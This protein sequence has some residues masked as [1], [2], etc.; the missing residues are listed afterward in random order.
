MQAERI[1]EVIRE[2][3]TMPLPRLVT[4]DLAAPFPRATRCVSIVGPRRAG[5]T[6]YLYQRMR[7]L[8]DAG[9]ERTRTLRLDFEDDRL[10]PA[11]GQDL[12]AVWR[13]YR[14]MYPAH[15]EGTTHL[16][17]DEVQAVDGWERFVR[18]LLDTQDVQVLLTG[19]SSRMLTSELASAMRGRSV[20]YVL[21]PY[22]FQE[23]VRARGR[24]VPEH[25]APTERAWTVNMLRDYL[26]F[27][28]FPEVAREDDAGA[29]VRKLSEYVDLM[30]MRD[31]V[32]RHGAKNIKALRL[33]LS[34]IMASVGSEFSVFKLRGRL[35][36]IGIDV[37]KDT[38]YAYMGHLVDAFAAF[39]VRR[40]EGSRW[41]S[42]QAL[43]K[44]YPIDTGYIAQSGG[45][46]AEDMG[47]LMECAV[48][49]E[50][51]RRRSTDP[52]MEFG[53]WRDR[54]GAEVDFVISQG[55]RVLQLVQSCYDVS[56]PNTRAREVASLLKAGRALGCD[57]LTVL[58]WDHEE[59]ALA[60]GR[61]V[62]F[63]PVWK[64][65]LGR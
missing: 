36:S 6:F 30:L 65:F 17:L 62:D 26:R 63:R 8:A 20:S 51:L 57:E 61:R 10:Y 18:R 47:R 28:G 7:D 9:V 42:E 53:F 46:S 44:V 45:R 40:W 58:T 54:N 35:A 4:R 49:V 31:V 12:D 24:E 19:S 55:A 64:W 27:G 41:A 39:Q 13:T 52:T 5:K 3:H 56:D 60:E 48:A 59:E 50:M 38:M 43:P 2:S 16:F 1:D 37:S 22:S 23:Y 15:S 32:E 11:T 33:M 34:A 29:K 14:S 21:L 25:Q